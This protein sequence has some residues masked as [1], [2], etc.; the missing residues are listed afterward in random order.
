MLHKLITYCWIQNLKIQPLDHIFYMFLTC[1]PISMPIG[2]NLLFD[3]EVGRPKNRGK[4]KCLLRRSNLQQKGVHIAAGH[5]PAA[6]S[7]LNATK[8]GLLQRVIGSLLYLSWMPLKQVYCDG[9]LARR[10]ST[11]Q[12]TRAIAAGI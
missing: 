6:I 8:T 12:N 10:Y 11:P 2:C 1:M 4:F 7:K 9:S 3:L 5:S